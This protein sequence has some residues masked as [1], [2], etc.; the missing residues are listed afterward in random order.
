MVHLG[1]ADSVVT[2]RLQG[3]EEEQYR[4]VG[5]YFLHHWGNL[6]TGDGLWE[7]EPGLQKEMIQVPS[8]V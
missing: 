2:D 3:P 8:T 5:G 1:N 7:D 6:D 4:G